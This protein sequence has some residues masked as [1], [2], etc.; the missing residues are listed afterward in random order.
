MKSKHHHIQVENIELVIDYEN[1]IFG[2]T[3][4]GKVVH[5]TE[6]SPY[7]IVIE[8]VIDYENYIFGATPDGKVVHPTE[9]SPYGIVEIKCSEEYKNNDP[10][11]TCYISMSSCLEIIDDNICRK[12]NH[13]YCDQVQMQLALT[14]QS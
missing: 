14:T 11:D 10:L 6:I 3:P 7:G 5:P 4:D 12:K 2:A 9:I 13:S 1:Y 8:L